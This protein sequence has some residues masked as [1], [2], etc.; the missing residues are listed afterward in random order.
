[1]IALAVLVVALYSP[2]YHKAKESL[3]KMK[4]EDITYKEQVINERKRIFLENL[5]E[6]N[7]VLIYELIQ[8]KL[9]EPSSAY[10]IFFD[11]ERARDGH[12]E[13][14][15]EYYLRFN[16]VIYQ[17]ISSFHENTLPNY[18][19][20]CFYIVNHDTGDYLTNTKALASF[21]DKTK[22]LES[23]KAS[24]PFFME[25]KTQGD[26]NLSI[27]DSKGL[28]EAEINWFQNLNYIND[29]I[30]A[31]DASFYSWLPYQNVAKSSNNITIIYASQDPNYYNSSYDLDQDY[32]EHYYWDYGF[33][34]YDSGFGV[35]IL[36]VILI[37]MLLAFL[38][39]L[40]KP[41]NI[42]KGIST[43]IPFEICAIFM[44]IALFI[45]I[46]EVSEF[47]WTSIDEG[48]VFNAKDS[49]LSLAS[50]RIITYGSNIFVLALLFSVWY[51]GMLSFRQITTLGPLR[52]IR[53]K[54]IIGKTITSIIYKFRSLIIT[55][56]ELD[57]T[58][59]TRKKIKWLLFLHFII[60]TLICCTWFIGILLLIPYVLV[61]Y[62][63]VCKYFK[64]MKE[65]YSILLDTTIQIAN[66]NLEARIDQH[67][68]I[69]EPIKL[70]L[71]KVQHGFQEAVWE[72]TKSERM[73]TELITNV[74][75]DL[76]TPLTAIIT[77]IGLLKD[78]HVTE[79]ERRSYIETL[80][81]KSQRLKVLIEDLF[82]VSKAA[83]NN[84]TLTLVEVELCNLIKQV[85]YELDDKIIAAKLDVRL[86]FPETKVILSLD[87]EKTYRI[88][89]NLIINITKYAA[90]HTRAYI[91]LS[92]KEEVVTVELKNISETEL[93]FSAQEITERFVRGDLSRNTEGSGLGL[94]ITKSFVELQGGTFA[95]I[96]D[97]DLFKAVIKWKLK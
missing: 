44:G 43:R 56:K 17:W 84:I 24:Y 86:N 72:E 62:Y 51:V 55:L 95:I 85:L 15:D 20:L 52:F 19:S 89:E 27:V 34:F 40:C 46:R 81:L 39:P 30:T 80:D 67:L 14:Y 13:Y 3:S 92:M 37:I 90:P 38:L 5:Y 10:D 66:G 57:F 31:E 16:E 48:F 93:N 45:M 91:D 96:V 28:E 50:Q 32:Y 49:I 21:A 59:K 41:A 42:G 22:D 26:G 61:I 83:S 53:E 47:A 25:L 97:G 4:I 69:F 11:E 88:F 87:S 54:M 68:G 7:Y 65:Q 6:G 94:A 74:S 12:N 78:E 8:L 75:H 33:L 35:V 82:E 1:M 63:E 58:D 60:L 71:T 77:Y 70:E 18:S 9:K 73:K 79:E 36:G 76:K 23:E 2:I 29:I 64:K